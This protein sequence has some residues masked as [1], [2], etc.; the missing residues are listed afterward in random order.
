[1]TKRRALSTEQVVVEQFTSYRFLLNRST[2]MK[3]VY[4]DE[5]DAM[6]LHLKSK[7]FFGSRIN[8]I[9]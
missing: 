5:V 4:H 1:M 8:A 7:Q 3:Q 2:D 6:N 9:N